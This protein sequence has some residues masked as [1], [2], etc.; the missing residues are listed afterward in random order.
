MQVAIGYEDGSDVKEVVGNNVAYYD[1][2][3]E[4]AV[5][6]VRSIGF[7]KFSVID[8]DED[9]K[10]KYVPGSMSMPDGAPDMTLRLA[11]IMAPF[12]ASVFHALGIKSVKVRYED[13]D[14]YSV[15]FGENQED[16][17][18]DMRLKN[19]DTSS[20][21]ETV[22]KLLPLEGRD[23]NLNI[24]LNPTM[25]SVRFSPTAMNQLGKKWCDFLRNNL[26]KC[27][28]MNDDEI[29]MYLAHE[30]VFDDAKDSG[31]INIDVPG[32][33]SENKS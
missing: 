1:R 33:K 31:D 16:I 19:L 24:D 15:V 14:P 13:G 17:D 2:V 10:K 8:V 5:D 25:T 20:I 9:G 21:Y 30:A 26:S 3:V 18:R 7:D 12:L 32:E 23:Y 6:L 27:L 11:N 22:A 28:G 4:C 29:E